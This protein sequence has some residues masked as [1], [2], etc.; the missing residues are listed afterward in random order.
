MQK[1]KK[2]VLV[3]GLGRFGSSIVES[4]W[5]AAGVETVAVDEQADAVDV[6]RDRA[7]AA[8]VGNA[9]DPK[10]L[11]G[12]GASECDVAVV[13]FGEDFEATVLCV[14]ELK[15]LGVREIVARAATQ[16]Q[17][18]VLRA[19][20][21]TRVYQ[22]EHEMGRR[23]SV[24]LVTP[25]AADLLEFAHQHQIHPWAANGKLV[26]STL[27][28]A[29]MRKRFGVTVLGYRRVGALTDGGMKGFEVAGPQYRIAEG[30][31]LLLVG[32]TAAMQRFVT[33][34]GG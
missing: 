24:D 21:A 33:Q 5:R 23:V 13:T 8:F 17:V 14:A 30:D 28:E 25:I 15:R 1:N 27:A 3:I 31:V 16:R 6:V 2:K 22:L 29:E 10:V 20:G 9:M 32:E 12:I 18:G 19:V 34:M 4:L 26:G 7:D 11:E